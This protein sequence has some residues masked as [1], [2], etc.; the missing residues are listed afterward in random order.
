MVLRG[1]SGSVE[2]FNWNCFERC[3]VSKSRSAKFYH[4]K[5]P[6]NIALQ[7]TNL[8]QK[9]TICRGSRYLIGLDIHVTGQ[10][11]YSIPSK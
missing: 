4:E 2:F 1:G 11:S 5:T 7:S 10:I 8:S 3:S 6:S 9:Y